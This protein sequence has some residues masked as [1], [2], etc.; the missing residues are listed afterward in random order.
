MKENGEL[1][2][3]YEIKNDVESWNVFRERYISMKPEIALEVSTS[4]KYVA[5]ML[6]DMGFSIQRAREYT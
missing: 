5:R 4:G 6:R 3:L 1:G 2:N